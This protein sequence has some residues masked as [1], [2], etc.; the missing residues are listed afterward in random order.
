MATIEEFKFR[1]MR[2]PD[3]MQDAITRY[4]ENGINP[5]SFLT[6]VICNDLQA[7]C[8]KADNENIHIIPAYVAYFYNE[9]PSDCC[10]SF[11]KM[12]SWRESKRTSNRLKGCLWRRK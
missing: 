7:A 1:G 8:A 10:G 6:A 11:E 2:I 4:V 9:A 12:K 3:R 5:G